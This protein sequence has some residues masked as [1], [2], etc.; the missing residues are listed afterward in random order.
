MEEWFSDLTT[1]EKKG[2]EEQSKSV[3][4]GILVGNPF[5]MSQ[6]QKRKQPAAIRAPTTKANKVASRVSMKERKKKT[7]AVASHALGR[8]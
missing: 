6:S 5:V 4:D 8:S 1:L 3:Q 2:E 7:K